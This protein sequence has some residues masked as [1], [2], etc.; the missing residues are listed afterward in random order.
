MVLLF[1]T[2][3][4]YDSLYY[5]PHNWLLPSLNNCHLHEISLLFVLPNICWNNSH[6]VI[7]RSYC[8]KTLPKPMEQTIEF[9]Y[10][11]SLVDFAKYCRLPAT[12]NAHLR[13]LTRQFLGMTKMPLLPIRKLPEVSSIGQVRWCFMALGAPGKLLRWL[14]C[15]NM[16]AG[17]SSQI[18]GEKFG[19]I[20]E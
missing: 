1:A 8:D 17:M 20:F 15:A 10:F 7:A 5:T 18:L 9:S 16:F 4:K 11:S 3:K 14:F 12:S 13:S 19:T 2:S 6:E